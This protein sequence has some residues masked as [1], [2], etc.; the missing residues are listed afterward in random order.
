MKFWAKKRE[1]EP[2]TSIA[3]AAVSGASREELLEQALKALTHD[4]LAD[5][6]GVWIEPSP[7]ASPAIEFTGAF[8]GQAWDHGS[9]DSCPPG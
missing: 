2:S 7:N 9:Q 8:C 5:R 3:C 4:H 6:V 1:E